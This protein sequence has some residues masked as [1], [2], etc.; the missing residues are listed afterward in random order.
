MTY[1]NFWLT[2]GV[3]SFGLACYTFI[4]TGMVAVEYGMP[5][6]YP[7]GETIGF[8]FLIEAGLGVATPLWRTVATINLYL[9]HELLFVKR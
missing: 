2:T 5:L 1:N 3:L 6:V 7:I 8:L 4:V 9:L